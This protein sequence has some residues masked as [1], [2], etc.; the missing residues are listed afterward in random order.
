MGKFIFNFEESS[1][2]KIEFSQFFILISILYRRLAFR[3]INF[4]LSWATLKMALKIIFKEFQ[5]TKG[6]LFF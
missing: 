6:A 3:N 2:L 1:H 4:G 5:S